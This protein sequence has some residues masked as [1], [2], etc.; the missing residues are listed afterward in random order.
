MLCTFE[1]ILFCFIVLL[2]SYYIWYYRKGVLQDSSLYLLQAIHNV[3][4]SLRVQFIIRLVCNYFYC[5]W[6]YVHHIIIGFT[7]KG[8]YIYLLCMYVWFTRKTHPI[9][10]VA[11][12][13]YTWVCNVHGNHLWYFY[14][15][16]ITARSSYPVIILCRSTYSTCLHGTCTFNGCGNVVALAYHTHVSYSCP[17]I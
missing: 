6:F 2:F 16:C 13:T 3:L 15:K 9:T 11:H 5:V 4:T 17:N 7:G 12:M 14:G 8:V 1:N 10:S